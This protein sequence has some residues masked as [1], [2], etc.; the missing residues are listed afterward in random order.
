M[1]PTAAEALDLFDDLKSSNIHNVPDCQILAL[2]SQS[3]P[4]LSAN[5]G[6]GVSQTWVDQVLLSLVIR[7]SLAGSTPRS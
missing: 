5:E 3:M 1:G 6:K 4:G 7:Y 2:G